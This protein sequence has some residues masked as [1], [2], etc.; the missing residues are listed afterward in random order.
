MK[1]LSRNEYREEE[2]AAFIK[3]ELLQLLARDPNSHMSLRIREADYGSLPDAERLIATIDGLS[4][5]LQDFLLQLGGLID[6][7]DEDEA[8]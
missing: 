6:D 2:V 3:E 8:A 5:A 7:V 4:Q 1:P